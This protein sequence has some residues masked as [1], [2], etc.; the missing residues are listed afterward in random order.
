ML[1]N[2]PGKELK[3]KK[4]RSTPLTKS[5]G[6]TAKRAA[7]TPIQQQQ[8]GPSLSEA[9]KSPSL[10]T[11]DE[12][13][14]VESLFG[15]DDAFD[16]IPGLPDIQENWPADKVALLKDMWR[17]VAATHAQ[18]AASTMQ[19]YEVYQR[20]FVIYCMLHHVAEENPFLVNEIKAVN[21]LNDD[22]LQ[23]ETCTVRKALQARS[24]I[25]NLYVIQ[26][27]KLLWTE[28]ENPLGILLRQAIW[29]FEDATN[30]FTQAVHSAMQRVAVKPQDNNNGT[31][32]G[33]EVVNSKAPRQRK[34][35]PTKKTSAKK[36]QIHD[37]NAS[38]IEESKEPQPTTTQ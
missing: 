8:Q 7:K 24:S 18:G 5:P 6:M 9:P 31:A 21:F 4:K 20:R 11:G 37:E 1:H 28:A 12:R 15:I 38:K 32:Q 30:N 13:E 33:E 27:T 10:S 23:D 14:I 29:D 19:T 25:S 36:E 22:L 34:P 17:A 2:E 35:Q 26:R 16:D 3:P